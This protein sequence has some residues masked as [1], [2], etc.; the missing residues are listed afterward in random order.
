VARIGEL[1]R[2]LRDMGVTVLLA[3]QDMHFASASP[4]MPW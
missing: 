2:K 3:E 4:T 1:L